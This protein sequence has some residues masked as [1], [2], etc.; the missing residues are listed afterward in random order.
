MKYYWPDLQSLKN[1]KHKKHVLNT[2]DFPDFGYQ[3]IDHGEIGHKNVR[4]RITHAY[5]LTKFPSFRFQGESH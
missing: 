5:Y 3:N 4:L 1:L 2:N